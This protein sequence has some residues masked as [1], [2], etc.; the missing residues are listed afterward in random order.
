[1]RAS[2]A[3]LSTLFGAPQFL[4]ANLRG[5]GFNSAKETPFGLRVEDRARALGQ[6]DGLV[7]SIRSAWSIPSG[8]AI[9]P[10]GLTAAARLRGV[11]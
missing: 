2:S 4:T 3:V 6:Q 10:E 11:H 1:M 8:S 7:N 5:A 9:H